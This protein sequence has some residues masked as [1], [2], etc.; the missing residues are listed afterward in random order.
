MEEEPQVDLL[1][2]IV[3][4]AAA[5][6]RD[7][8]LGKLLK[9]LLLRDHLASIIFHFHRK[10]L[11]AAFRIFIRLDRRFLEGEEFERGSHLEK[12]AMTRTRL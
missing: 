9:D 11:F 5:G 3:V 4:T 12:V 8:A 1:F 7:L 10:F 2:G 6:Q